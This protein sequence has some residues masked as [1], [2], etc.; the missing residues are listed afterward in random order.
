MKIWF[1]NLKI[2]RRLL[3]AFGSILLLLFIT[4]GTGIIGLRTIGPMFETTYTKC[5]LPLVELDK[6]TRNWYKVRIDVLKIITS[7]NTGD[8]EHLQQESNRMIDEINTSFASYEK[9]ILT[10]SERQLANDYKQKV[11]RYVE[12]R[13]K[14][15]ALAANNQTAEARAM[16]DTETLGHFNA[17]SSSLDRLLATQTENANALYKSSQDTIRSTTLTLFGV[18]GL[19]LLVGIVLSRF[20]G[21]SISHPIILLENTAK[22]VAA[23]NLDA[24]VAIDT[25][26]EIGSLTTSFNTMVNS[27]RTGMKEVERKSSEAEEAAEEARRALEAITQLSAEV[28]MVTEEVSLHTAGISSSIEQMAAGAEEQA[29]QTG[30]VAAA[31]EEMAQTIAETTQSISV[32]AQSSLQAS[33]T[34]HEGIE[35]VKHTRA[36]MVRIVEVTQTSG[37]KIER[38]SEKVEEVGSI[39][40]VINDIADQTNLLALNAAIEAARAGEHGR[41]FAVVADEV[42]KLAERTGKATKE[43]SGVLKAI[44]DETT[45]ARKSM[46][47]AGDVVQKE[48]VSTEVLTTTFDRIS[49][50]SDNVTSLIN[51]IA[52]ASEEQS[53]TMSAVSKNIE[54]MRAVSEQS[55]IGVQQIA[56]ATSQLNSLTENLRSLVEQFSHGTGSQNSTENRA[57]AYHPSSM[58][59]YRQDDTTIYTRTFPKR[60]VS[61]V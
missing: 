40:Q 30:E 2:G 10:E 53:L 11:D 44:Q 5:V 3:I 52:V 38:L 50:E 41:G 35:A 37:E 26:D 59:E 46:E 20:I 51:Q 22:E 13:S 6:V 27:I 7:A 34:A 21:R 43:I 61:R 8:R 14:V 29:A 15:L 9:T 18:L 25:R 19:S 56:Q 4:G 28:Q 42:R 17:M 36:S 45:S 16:A 60:Q 55:A 58:R 39:T 54:G 24:V 33:N 1:A 12:S 47:E 48:L 57:V 31:T 32:T 23:G 49:S